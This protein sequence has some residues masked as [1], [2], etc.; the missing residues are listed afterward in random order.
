MKALG[1][2]I[3]LAMTC[4]PVAQA[5]ETFQFDPAQSSISFKIRHFLG[6]A[7]GRFTKFS[8]T[9]EV[10]RERP[11]QSSVVATIQASSIDTGIAKRDEHLRGEDFFD[12]RKFPV[13]IFKSARVKQTGPNGGEI[14]GELTIHGITRPITLKAQLLEATE[15]AAKAQKTRWRVA[16]SLNRSGFKL[17][18]NRVASSMIGEEVAIDIQIEAEREK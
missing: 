5:S 13:I 2:A 18:S 3:I 4:S 9:I 14:A 6:T 1:L 11:E 15:S 8:G 12:V 16:T 7:K 17:G 10:D